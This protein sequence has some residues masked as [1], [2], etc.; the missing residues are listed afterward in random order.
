MCLTS[1][2]KD[3]FDLFHEYKVILGFVY[4]RCLTKLFS[5]VPL[6]IYVFRIPNNVDDRNIAILSI[7]SSEYCFTVLKYK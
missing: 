6:L 5:I 4:N 3:I 2:S 7:V 1:L